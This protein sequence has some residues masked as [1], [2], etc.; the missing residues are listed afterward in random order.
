LKKP[1][2][3]FICVGLYVLFVAA[4]ICTSCVKRQEVS[5]MITESKAIEVAKEEFAKTGRKIEDYRV[6]VEADSTGRKWIVWF[7][8][9][10]DS[11]P[12]G[13]RHCVSVEKSGGKATFMPGE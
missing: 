6:S 5:P 4:F 11:L 13:G 7:E 8:R 9:K 12:V 1:C 2:I 10:G 3:K